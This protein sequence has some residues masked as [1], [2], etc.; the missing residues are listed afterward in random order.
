MHQGTIMTVRAQ[1]YLIMDVERQMYECPACGA[2]CRVHQY[3]KKL[4]V[5]H[6]LDEDHHH[7]G[8]YPEVQVRDL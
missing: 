7:R 5:H 2:L 6:V 1:L 3:E 4:F 8:P